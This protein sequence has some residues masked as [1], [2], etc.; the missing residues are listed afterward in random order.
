LPPLDLAALGPGSSRSTAPER[1][2]GGDR[3]GVVSGEGGRRRT[4]SSPI[5]T[6]GEERRGKERRMDGS[7][8]AEG[9]EREREEGWRGGFYIGLGLGTAIRTIRSKMDGQK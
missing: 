2:G 7:V 4:L 3:G 1:G 8:A 6:A 5:P 9:G